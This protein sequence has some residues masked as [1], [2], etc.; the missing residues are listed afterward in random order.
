MNSRQALGWLQGRPSRNEIRAC[1]EN[2]RIVVQNNKTY[3]STSLLLLYIHQFYSILLTLL[4]YLCG[5]YF[6]FSPY[7]TSNT[8]TVLFHN[9]LIFSYLYKSRI[10]EYYE[11]QRPYNSTFEL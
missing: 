4:T 8:L 6:D 1:G 10:Y 3:L 5:P 7:R 2:L 9:F 11:T